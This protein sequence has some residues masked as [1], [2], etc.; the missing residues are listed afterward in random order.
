MPDF[1]APVTDAVEEPAADFEAP[2][3]PIAEPAAE[4]SMDLADDI[5]EG[6]QGLLDDTDEAP[7]FEEPKVKELENLSHFEAVGDEEIDLS[8]MPPVKDDIPAVEEIADAE[9]EKPSVPNEFDAADFGN[10]DEVA[11]PSILTPSTTSAICSEAWAAALMI[12]LT[13]SLAA[14]LE[15]ALPEETAELLQVPA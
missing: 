13:V 9:E 15:E 14:V 11:V 1:E 6:F 5:P 12:S 8:Q 4:P 3:E 7:A 2:S 10:F